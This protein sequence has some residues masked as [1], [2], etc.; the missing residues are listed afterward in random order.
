[1]APQIL[2]IQRRSQLSGYSAYCSIKRQIAHDESLT[3]R[4][5]TWL[6]QC[7]LQALSAW[8]VGSIWLA[9]GGEWAERHELE[10]FRWELKGS[11]II[12]GKA[13]SVMP[14]EITGGWRALTEGEAEHAHKDLW[15]LMGAITQA[16]MP[17]DFN[18]K[19]RLS[20]QELKAYEAADEAGRLE[21]RHRVSGLV[22]ER[23]KQTAAIGW[24]A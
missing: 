13:V 24:A 2:L 12:H 6:V 15:G 19:L 10:S 23:R 22:K 11:T 4:V 1:M 14:D 7:P 20:P 18:F 3:P 8:R 5:L 16:K 21:M 17:L 9:H